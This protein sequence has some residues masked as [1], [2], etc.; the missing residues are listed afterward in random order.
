MSS[1]KLD[2]LHQTLELEASLREQLELER[3]LTNKNYQEERFDVHNA[4]MGR[5]HQT[6]HSTDVGNNDPHHINSVGMKYSKSTSSFFQ[7]SM[8]RRTPPLAPISFDTDTLGSAKKYQAVTHQIAVPI[9][10]GSPKSKRA[11]HATFGFDFGRQGAGSQRALLIDL[12]TR[13]EISTIYR[14]LH[15]KTNAM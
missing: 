3:L 11:P 10:V 12:G 9:A 15:A 13:Q 8:A 6:D 5:Y 2:V 7:P 14:T 1:R 4:G